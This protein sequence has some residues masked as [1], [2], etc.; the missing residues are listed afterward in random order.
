MERHNEVAA[1]H[2]VGHRAEAA[3][4]GAEYDIVNVPICVCPLLCLLLFF[5]I[6]EVMA[7]GS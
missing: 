1:V 2:V 6:I 3:G 4:A 5:V 7:S